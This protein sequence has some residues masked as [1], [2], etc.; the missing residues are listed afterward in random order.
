MKFVSAGAWSVASLTAALLAVSPASADFVLVDDFDD[1]MTGP[2]DGQGGW[3]AQSDTSVVTADP[4][5][6]D[7]LVLAVTTDSTDLH[8]QTIIL[9]DTVRMLFFRF[10]IGGQQNFSVGMSDSTFPDQFGNF[11]PELGMSNATNELRIN[12]G[13][14]YEILTVL[15]PDT[16]YNCWMLIDNI[17][18][19]TQVYL[20]ARAGDAA[21][22]SDQLDAEGQTV[23]QFRGGT[24]G[25][26]INYFIK[27]GGGS[28]P[29]GPL[30][31]DDIYLENADALNLQNP[32][33]AG[34]PADFNG[35]GTVNTAD[36]LFL[37][38]AWGTDEGDVNDDGN[39][40]TADLL[41]LLAA[42]GDCP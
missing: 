31:L 33:G 38:G 34:C 8:R 37:L 36:L 16:W 28:G 29:S 7:N 17:D 3:Y 15:E 27:T 26:L 24:A 40:D 1:F 12:D 21:E 20:H 41:A 30:Y 35:D 2:V 13:G 10:R 18:D 4:A 39:T 19:T 32:A 11:E 25:D 5:D 9:D 23:F 14:T 22:S 6:M 42:W